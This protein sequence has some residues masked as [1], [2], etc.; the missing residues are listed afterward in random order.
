MLV[1][2]NYGR[3]NFITPFLKKDK[4]QDLNKNQ[5]KL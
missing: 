3:M 4:V 2:T 1:I 5:L